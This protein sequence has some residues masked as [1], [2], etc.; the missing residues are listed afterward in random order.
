MKQF[1][2]EVLKTAARFVFFR[3][4]A[5]EL[6]SLGKRH[7]AVG[8]VLVWLA[9][10]GRHWDDESAGFL[11]SSGVGS[12]VY[13]F[14]LA[15]YL[16]FALLALRPREW[17]YFRVLTVICLTAP[18]AF[19]YAIPIE[20]WL[21][22]DMARQANMWALAIVALWRVALFVFFL[23]R[24]ARLQLWCALSGTLFPISIIVILLGMMRIAASI[25]DAMAG[26]RAPRSD[27]VIQMTETVVA[28]SVFAFI[29]LLICYVAAIRKAYYD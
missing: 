8:L 12:L 28:I 11:Q 3:A 20:R 26:T 23:V 6:E 7:L 24:S 29:P 5:H 19:L 18:P 27:P 21:E 15:L 2:L 13:V 25:S 22:T 16:W 1:P 17:N 10:I 14:V 4:S 9:G